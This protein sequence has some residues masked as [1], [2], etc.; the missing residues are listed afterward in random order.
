LEAEDFARLAGWVEETRGA[1]GYSGR[2]FMVDNMHAQAVFTTT[3]EEAGDYRV[4]A[5][6]YRTAPGGPP[7]LLGIRDRVLSFGA[8]EGTGHWVW[9]LSGS[10]SLPAGPLALALSR[11]TP[12]GRPYVPLLVDTLLLVRDPAFDPERE[13]EW[14]QVTDSGE[15]P[16]GPETPYT[17]TFTGA[18]GSYRCRVRAFAGDWL[19]DGQGQRGAGSAWLYFSIR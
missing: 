2:A 10:L 15:Q 12:P 13:D 19:V 9:E 3:V 17:Y 11:E 14:G 5:R 6:W 8:A 4:W 7:A 1:P 16:V 18:P